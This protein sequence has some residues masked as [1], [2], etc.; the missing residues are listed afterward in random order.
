MGE[1][2]SLKTGDSRPRRETGGRSRFL[3][4]EETL[5]E[6]ARRHLVPPVSPPNGK[7]E[8]PEVLDYTQFSKAIEQ[9]LVASFNSDEAASAAWIKAKPIALGSW[10]RGQLCPKSDLDLLFVGDQDAAAVVTRRSQEAGL[11]IRSRVPED[12]GDWT[13]GVQA[14][15]VLALLAAK[16]LTDG[17]REAFEAQI[18]RLTPR[19]SKLRRGYFSALKAERRERNE[20][21]D[22]IANFLEPN[23][24]YGPGGLFS[25]DGFFRKDLR[26]LTGRMRFRSS[27]TIVAFFF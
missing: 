8:N 1:G 10:A 21:F 15:D 6:L 14:F 12:P 25:C 27:T 4:P 5:F 26:V 19:L 17:A 9:A 2:D 23:L 16:P 3:L 11:K 22:S 20:R 7:E 18:A 24:K 13:L